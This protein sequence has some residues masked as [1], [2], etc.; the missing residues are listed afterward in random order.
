VSTHDER[1]AGADV[2]LHDVAK[3]GIQVQHLRQ[4]ICWP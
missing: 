1:V 3:Y 2:R 4:V